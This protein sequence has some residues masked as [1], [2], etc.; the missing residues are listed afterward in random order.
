MFDE[1]FNP[2]PCVA[3]PVHTVVAPEPANSTGI[4]SSTIIDQDAPSPNF[5]QMQIHA[6]MPRVR[7]EV[8]SAVA[9][10]PAS[11]VLKPKRLIE[12]SRA[13]RINKNLVRTHTISNHLLNTSSSQLY[14]K[15]LTQYHYDICQE[16]PS[17]ITTSIITMK[18]EILLGDSSSN[19]PHDGREAL[20]TKKLLELSFLSSTNM[21]DAKKRSLAGRSTRNLIQLDMVDS[22][23]IQKELTAEPYEGDSEIAEAWFDQAAEYWKQA[24][25]LTPGNYIEAL[26]WLKITRRFE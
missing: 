7:E 2:P 9:I 25:A 21:F 23:G 17:E 13:K 8:T 20:R 5:M 14:P 4:P 22:N 3:S 26:N 10:S 1:H 19:K 6:V 24:I 15:S 18:M 16:H 12:S 11:D